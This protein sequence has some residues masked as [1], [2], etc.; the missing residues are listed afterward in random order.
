MIATLCYQESPVMEKKFPPISRNAQVFLNSLLTSFRD[1]NFFEIQSW[2]REET[3]RVVR[4]LVS[5]G[6]CYLDENN[7]VKYQ[8]DKE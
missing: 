4:E 8:T 2:R 7:V 1:L 3:T 5:S 6:Y